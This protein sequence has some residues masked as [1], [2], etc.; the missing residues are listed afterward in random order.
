MGDVVVVKSSCM[1]YCAGVKRAVELAA[2]ALGGSC[3][4][5]SGYATNKIYCLGDLIHNDAVMDNLRK[6]GLVVLDCV[7]E[8]P[9][10]AT[11]IIRAHGVPL[12]EMQQLKKMGCHVIDAT[13]ARVIHS[14]KLVKDYSSRGYTIFFCGDKGHAEVR[15]VESYANYEAASDGAF[16]LL[17]DSKSVPSDLP[18]GKCVLLAQTT[19][20]ES[21]FTAIA[22][23]LSDKSY[24][25]IIEDTIC[26]ATKERQDALR[27]LCKEVDCVLVV[28]STKSRN[29][30]SLLQ[31]ARDNC[32]SA[33]LIDGISA[34][35][36]IVFSKKNIRIGITA[37][38]STPECLINAV[39]DKLSTL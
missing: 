17:S 23:A 4:G 28:G 21:E 11:V 37:G 34:L 22:K 32:D 2:G 18:R 31:I 36:N 3:D 39:L 30:M 1:G 8:I 38:A 27:F 35:D 5:E 7:S 24:D 26:R 9:A 15:S 16:I 10:G 6:M 12:G 33:Y 13:C 14:Q 20:K 19:F 29:T 25:I